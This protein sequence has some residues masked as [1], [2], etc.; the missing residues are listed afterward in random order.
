MTARA[1]RI[2]YASRARRDLRRLDPSIRSRLLLAVER[3]AAN[4]LRADVRKITGAD[5]YRMRVG[6]WRVRFHRSDSKRE[7]VVLRVLPRGRAY[8][9]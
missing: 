4:D 6:E 2:R 7:I 3:L 8:D 9:R 5:E 1:W